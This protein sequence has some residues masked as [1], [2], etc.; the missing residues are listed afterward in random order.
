VDK[1]LLQDKVFRKTLVMHPLPRVDELAYE[2]DADERSMYFKQAAH[3]VPI[4]MALLAAL[5]GAK[6]F[7]VPDMES[8]PPVPYPYYQGHPSP[9]C[10]N[11]R[12]VSIQP[13]ETKYLKPSFKIVNTSPLTLRCVYCE[14]GFEPKY[15]A[16]TDWHEHKLDTKK[17]HSAAS[18]WA[19]YIRPENLIVFNTEAEAEA[20][21]YKP[22]HFVGGRR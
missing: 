6:E 11:P 5:L 8:P 3:G 14:H 22:S 17:Y 15:V 1:K 9:V 10:P 21:G 12:C 18:H 19:K 7:D 4:R 20:H 13:T 16:S 2:I